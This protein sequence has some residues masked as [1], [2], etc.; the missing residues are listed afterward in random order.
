MFLYD[1]EGIRQH[2]EGWEELVGGDSGSTGRKGAMLESFL[3]AR[4][5]KAAGAATQSTIDVLV[6]YTPAARARVGAAGAS[7][8]L[9]LE[10]MFADTNRV[11]ERSGLD[12]RFRLV[13]AVEV[14]YRQSST[15]MGEDLCKLT[16]RGRTWG[17]YLLR[18]SAGGATRPEALDELHELRD[19]YQADLVALAVALNAE[20][21]AGIAWIAPNDEQKG[22]T[23]FAAE[24]E[25]AGGYVFA[26]E[27]IH[28]LGG[29]HNPGH[30]SPENGQPY[31]PYGHGRCNTVEGWHTVMSY[32][33]N[34]APYQTPCGGFNPVPALSSPNARG[35]YGT[36]T[37][38]H[39]T[40]YVAR[41]VG[42]TTAMVAAHR[43][44]T[45][46]EAVAHLLPFMPGTQAQA[47]GLQ[48]FVRILN[49]STRGGTIA[50][51][52][53]DD[54]GGIRRT[55]LDIGPFMAR[56]FNSQDLESGDTKGLG[57]GI[58]RGTGHRRLVLKSD[59]DLTVLGYVRTPDGFVTSTHETVESVDVAEGRLAGIHFFNPGSNRAVA[60]V[61]RIINPQSAPAQVEIVGFDD[62]GS[63]GDSPITFAVPARSARNLWSWE[64]EG[65]PAFAGGALGDGDGKWALLVGSD[66][67]VEV[68]SLLVSQSGYITNV[69]R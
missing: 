60:S 10:A 20:G 5:R 36:P 7:V 62:Q 34:G 42:E 47:S 45:P 46:Q 19:R 59:L 69:S 16:A 35:P 15:N 22:F 31:Q 43:G 67:P 14:P 3:E 58:G 27:T 61:L 52:A 65:G 18:C 57:A 13:H 23:V 48:G 26:H 1:T 51:E 50:I 6:A 68:M 24:S 11:F 4:R 56:H 40:H 8:E 21:T 49:A 39:H 25:L 53:T 12:T 28:N 2:P 37:G 66:K 44:Q 54:A 32:Q 9:A 55:S 30:A 38:D 41:L 29:G 17:T 64:L 33:N 63:R